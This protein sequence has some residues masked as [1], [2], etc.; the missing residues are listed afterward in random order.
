MRAIYWH[1]DGQRFLIST[2]PQTGKFVVV[3]A[4]DINA[5]ARQNRQRRKAKHQK[6]AQPSPNRNKANSL[7]D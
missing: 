4:P 7:S 5:A 3:L 2:C 1:L 6:P